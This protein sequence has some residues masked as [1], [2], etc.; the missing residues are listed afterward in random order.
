QVSAFGDGGEGDG[1]D[2]W[3]V[4]CMRRDDESWSRDTSVRLRHVDTQK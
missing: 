2:S 4:E 1:G 3:K